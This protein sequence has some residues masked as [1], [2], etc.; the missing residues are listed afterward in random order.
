MNG[1]QVGHTTTVVWS[2]RLKRNLALAMMDVGY[3]N[4]EQ[5]V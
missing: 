5:P 4:A 2:L 1:Q 3:W